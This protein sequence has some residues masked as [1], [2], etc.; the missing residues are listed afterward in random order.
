MS[1]I[2]VTYSGLISFF[3]G[4]IRLPVGLIFIILITRTLTP[5][6]FGTYNLIL[7]LIAYLMTLPYILSYWS[8]R[9]IARNVE[10]GKT[11]ALSSGIFS[12]F[13]V[14]IYI[15]IAYF[16]SQETAVNQNVLLFSV[17][18]VPVVFFQTVLSGINLGWKP[19]VN[20]YGL[21]VMEFVRIPCAYFFVYNFEMGVI[22]VILAS[23]IGYIANI[24]VLLLKNKEKIKSKFQKKFFK[25]WLRRSWIPAYPGIASLIWALD[26]LIFT[27]I[28]GSVEGVGY[29]SAAALIGT[30]VL[31]SHQI[32]TTGVYPKLLEGGA[33][34]YLQD[35]LTRV[36]YFAV[37]LAT[38]SIFF[39]ESVLFTLNP[40][41]QGVWWAVVFLTLRSFCFTFF[42][43]FAHILKG[44]EKVDL[45][46][47]ST[48]KE[49][50]KS[51]L[52][53]VPTI[54]LIAN[55]SYVI[56]LAVSLFVFASN[57]TLIDL[58]IYWSIIQLLTT[59]PFTI[60]IILITKRKIT[61]HFEFVYIIKY[62]LVSIIA[63]GSTYLLSTQFLEFQKDLFKFLPNL[64]VF[65]GLGIIT[66]IIITFVIDQKTRQL[67]KAI[68]NEFKTKT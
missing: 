13:G 30:F 26:A 35:N 17:I 10:S 39:A 6:E 54:Q 53:F 22:G 41:Y 42:N 50:L 68:I 33:K 44:D 47:S 4:M 25:S 32:A 15:I 55:M 67:V 27:L 46:S 36:F 40:L 62:F 9:E 31:Y 38:M 2:R 63:F 61:L 7:T 57:T 60:Y 34:E 16:V 1:G 64:L 19:Q 28:V 51:K 12:I 52:F 8:T 24:M 21:L 45:N 66:Y 43:I 14:V 11:A 3:V 56:I 58:V 29:F 20:S 37:P 23:F 49:Y 59:I 18:L 65:I 5:E 48:L